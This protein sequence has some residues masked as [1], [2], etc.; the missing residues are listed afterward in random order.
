MDEVLAAQI[1]KGPEK[2]LATFYSS[3]TACATYDVADG[4]LFHHVNSKKVLSL[5]ATLIG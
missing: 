4:S 3:S 1:I 2:R 5:K